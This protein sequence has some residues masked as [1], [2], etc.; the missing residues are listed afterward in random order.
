MD[1]YARIQRLFEGFA[2]KPKPPEIKS[3][4]SSF[5]IP[6]AEEIEE[7]PFLQA[8]DCEIATVPVSVAATPF[9]LHLVFNGTKLRI[10]ARSP[11]STQVRFYSGAMGLGKSTKALRELNTM[12][13]FSTLAALTEILDAMGLGYFGLVSKKDLP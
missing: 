4:T 10:F 9:E 7:F 12:P 13:S 5:H 11:L 1:S 8:E 3:W 6:T 2:N